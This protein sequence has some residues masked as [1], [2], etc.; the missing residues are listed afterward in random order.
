MLDIDFIRDHADIVSGSAKKKGFNTDIPGLLKA[1]EERRRLIKEVDDLRA[2]INEASS[3][4][5]TMGDTPDRQM[6]IEEMRQVKEALGV[7]EDTMRRAE[8]LFQNLM[9]TVPNVPDPSVPE[10]KT[11]EDNVEI[12]K[13]G[14]TPTFSFVVKDYMTIMRAHD[15]V[16]L[17]RGTKVAGFRGLFLK[18]DG[19][20]LS[21]ALWR[22]TMDFMA[23]RGFTEMIAPTLARERN[24]MGTGWFPLDAQNVYQTQDG[25]Y[26]VG[27]A[28][29]STMGYHADEILDAEELPKK[30]VA[31][32][33]CYRR[34]AGSHGKDTKGIY[35]V[36]EFYKVEQIILCKADH[37]ESVKYHEELLANS[38]SL[39]QSLEIPYRVVVNCAGDLGLGQVKK[40]DIES[41]VP[42]EQRYRETHSA[43]YFHAFQTRRLNIKYR[44]E[45]GKAVF[46][47]SLNNTAIATP[48]FLISFIE[49]HQQSDGS[50]RIPTA[51]VPYMG[52]ERIGS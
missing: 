41:W 23:A 27:T 24:F 8:E 34:E 18:G 3:R 9:L 15:L 28:E 2:K 25:L 52:K 1:D 19:A 37:Q 21:I 5:P 17:E 45:D 4:I 29:V 12:K 39:M 26:L 31:F 40:Y 33:P 10:G 20:R 14:E 16:D 6:L 35:R 47:H 51:L 30:Y 38:E 36:H 32:S 7:K 48:R 11:D 43:S 46:A 49:N 50:V 42:S 44:G 22:Y 13:V